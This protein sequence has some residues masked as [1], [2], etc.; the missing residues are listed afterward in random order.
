[1]SNALRVSEAASVGMHTMVL[2]AA[3]PGRL[4]TTREV[5]DT[6][7]VSEAHLSKVLQRLARAGFVRSVRGPR[8]GFQLADAP[9][10]ISLLQVYEAIEG[11]LEEG[12]CLLGRP[13]CDGPNCILGRLLKSVNQEVRQYLA[14]AKLS[15]LTEVFAGVE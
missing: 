14:G 2:L 9:D 13:V 12:N 10:K 8:G 4:M 15:E 3:N 5:A 1:M 6:L 11:P 7:G